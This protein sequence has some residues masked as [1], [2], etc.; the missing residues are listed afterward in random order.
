MKRLSVGD[1]ASDFSLP[2][3]F[4][5][6]ITLSEVCQAQNVLLVFNIGFA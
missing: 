6:M 5:V 1:S 4:G 2:N 3:Y